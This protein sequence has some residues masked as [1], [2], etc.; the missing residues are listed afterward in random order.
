M[1]KYAESLKQRDPRVREHLRAAGVRTRRA[2]ADSEYP[3]GSV[4]VYGGMKDEKQRQKLRSIG[5][6]TSGADIALMEE[7]NAFT[8]D[9]YDELCAACAA[10]PRHGPR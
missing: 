8:S 10:G 6:L 5:N 7:A 2:R 9:D 3:N 1:R 4:I